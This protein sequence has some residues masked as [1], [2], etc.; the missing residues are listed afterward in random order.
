MKLTIFRSSKGDALLISHPDGN[1]KNNHILVDGG[2]KTSFKNSVAPYLNKEIKENDEIIDLLCV[3][4][5]DNDHIVGIITLMELLSQWRVFNHHDNNPNSTANVTKPKVAEPPFIKSI[6]HNSFAKAYDLGDALPKVTQALQSIEQMTAN[7]IDTELFEKVNDRA[8]SVKDGITLS[9]R[10]RPEQLNI[11]LNPEYNGKIVKCNQSSIHKNEHV[12][13][14][15]NLSVIGPFSSDLTDLKNDWI[16][17]EKAHSEELKEFYADLSLTAL[18]QPLS[19]DQLSQLL[20]NSGTVSKLGDR[21]DVTTPNLASIMFLVEAEGKTI[22][23][24]GDGHSDDIIKGLKKNKKLS[25]NKTLHVD[26]LKIQHHGASANIDENFCK[27]IT[28]NHYVF[29]GNGTHTNPE[30]AVIDAICNSRKGTESQKS[31]NEEVDQPFTFWF[32]ANPDDK[33]TGR[34]KAHLTNISIKLKAF[35][36]LHSDFEFKFMPTNK[37]SQVIAL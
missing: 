13:G 15:I 37:H 28:A 14:A 1:G 4:H 2:M 32:S 9:Q 34:Q 21:D 16:K 27:T 12:V 29:C 24:T 10:I 30:E 25:S 5:I 23:M 11:E 31:E 17:W 35:N 26:V 7:F 8:T 22:L 36:A 3:S 18:N 33:L 20:I 19:M 6:W